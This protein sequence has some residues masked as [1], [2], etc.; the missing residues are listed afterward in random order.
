MPLVCHPERSEAAKRPNAVEEPAPSEAARIYAA[1]TN[2]RSL[3]S[4][5]LP[6]PAKG[7]RDV[8]LARPSLGMTTQKVVATM[9]DPAWSA[10]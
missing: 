7:R 9:N 3:D 10:K 2:R 5:R 8:I 6:H 1:P 4:G